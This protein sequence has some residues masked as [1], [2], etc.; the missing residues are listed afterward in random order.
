MT[1]SGGSGSDDISMTS[2]GDMAAY[3]WST[4]VV[5]LQRGGAMADG[6]ADAAMTLA[7]TLAG[8]LVE[9]GNRRR[10]HIT[11]LMIRKG[12]CQRAL[13]YAVGAMR[14]RG[15]TSASNRY[16]TLS[17][18]RRGRSDIHEIR[19][20]KSARSNGRRTD[21]LSG[22]YGIGRVIKNNFP[23]DLCPAGPL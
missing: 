8:G 1:S 13:R 6:G 16:L 20:M 10:Y 23:W 4:G 11:P 5:R 9:T 15:L 14:G 12:I 3:E 2:S 18:G 19:W 7:V 22:R 21:N 17:F